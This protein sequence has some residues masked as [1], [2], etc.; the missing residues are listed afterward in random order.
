MRDVG[1]GCTLFVAQ[2]DM[3]DHTCSVFPVSMMS[4]MRR[5][6]RPEMGILD[7]RPNETASS[8]VVDTP[9]YELARRKSICVPSGSGSIARTKSVTIEPVR[10]GP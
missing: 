8:P 5:M 1:P 4:S 6:C 7:T 3:T 10:P 9:M 2:H